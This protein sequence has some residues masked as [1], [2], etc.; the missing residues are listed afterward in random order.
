MST[1]QR[2]LLSLLSATVVCAAIIGIASA[3]GYSDG[4]GDGRANGRRDISDGAW[5][6]EIGDR[7]A[8]G[9]VSGTNLMQVST[10][11]SFEGR[12]CRLDYKRLCPRTPIGQCDLE[13]MNEQLSP[14]CQAFVETHR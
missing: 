13:S 14:R 5:G 6:L 3:D 1:S 9:P 11:R 12:A 4:R 8:I 2:A 10:F 7:V